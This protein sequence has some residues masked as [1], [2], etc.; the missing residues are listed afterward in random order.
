MPLAYLLIKMLKG[1]RKGAKRL[2][3]ERFL[4]ALKQRGVHPEFTLT[5]KDW[6]EIGAF[7]TVWPVAKHQLCFWHGLRALKQRL[8]KSRLTPA[9]Y[10]V[11]A[12]RREFPYIKRSFVPLAQQTGSENVSAITLSCL[13]N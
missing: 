8:V 11:D 9:R 6:S 1:A 12:A 7:R 10:D 13:S 3:L 5:D 2:V 4:H